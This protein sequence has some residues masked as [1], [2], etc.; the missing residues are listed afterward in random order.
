MRTEKPK[1]LRA[2]WTNARHVDLCQ[3]FSMLIRRPVKTSARRTH[4]QVRVFGDRLGAR[5]DVQFFVNAADVGIHGRD[6]DLEF[7]RNLLVEKAAGEKLEH[8]AFALG[9]GQVVATGDR[10]S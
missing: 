10:K 3:R 6:A 8:F 5:T 7:V 9:Q 4:R 1:K 2:R